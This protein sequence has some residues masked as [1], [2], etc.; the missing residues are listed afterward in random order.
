MKPLWELLPEKVPSW[1]VLGRDEVAFHKFQRREAATQFQSLGS[2]FVLPWNHF[3]IYTSARLSG[4]TGEG[5]P[6]ACLRL[7]DV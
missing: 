4:E 2:D 3:Y 7:C 6:P 5:R 1:K